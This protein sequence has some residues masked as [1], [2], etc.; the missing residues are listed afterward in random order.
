[1]RDCPVR[2]AVGDTGGR[3]PR[4]G[5]ICR[6][7]GSDQHFIEDCLVPNEKSKH[8]GQR[9]RQKGPPKEIARTFTRH[10]S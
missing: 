8:L 2:D 1:M 6:A 3:K 7:C 9:D 10:C 5:Y 4:E